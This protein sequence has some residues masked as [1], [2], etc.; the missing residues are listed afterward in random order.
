MS[1]HT[2]L[3]TLWTLAAGDP[4]LLPRLALSNTEQSLPS[5]FPVGAL[6]A[7][8]IGAQALMAAELWRLRGGRA[9][10]VRVDQRH[11]LAM[12]RSERYLQVDGKPP[13]DPWSAIAGYYQAGDGRWIQ[14]HTNFPHHR[15]GVLQVLR[16]ADRRDA[17]AAAIRGWSAEALDARLAQEGLCAAL[18]RSPREWQVHPQAAAIAALPLF[19]LERLAETAPQALPADHR[20]R[21]LGGVRVLDLSRVI[22][23]P[24]AGRTLAQHGA[25]VLAISAAHLPN[26]ALLV[27]DTGRGKRPAQLDL[28]QDSGRERLRDLIRG[29]DVFIHAYRPGSLAARGFSSAELQALRPGLVEVSLS[30]YGQAG[31]WAQRRGFDSLVQ[32]ASGIAWT[33]GQ[34]QGLAQPGKLPCQALDHASGYI[35]ALG[36]M[37]ALK[38]RALQ[39]GGWRVSVSLAQ[40]G[41][42]LQSMA[43]LAGGLAQA[44]LDEQEIGPWRS[45]TA[46]RFGSVSSI[47]PAERMSATP[48]YFALPPAPLD[49]YPACWP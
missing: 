14:L 43:P 45:Q 23:A 44:E 41:A 35:A 31:P 24:V 49:A 17:V 39:G 32:S 9:Q 36:A 7:A 11:A 1:A 38:R 6:A 46:S 21:P 5:T 47:A 27:I 48:P 33:E 40:T 26:I 28:R 4:A 2:M 13:P 29:A 20:G 10:D 15:D 37:A 34:A 8:T 19:A 18:I 3:H 30:A 22:A 16:C 12:F 42:W 25:D